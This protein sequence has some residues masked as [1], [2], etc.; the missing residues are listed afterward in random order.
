MDRIIFAGNSNLQ[1]LSW[2]F[3]RVLKYLKPALDIYKTHSELDLFEMIVH[4]SAYLVALKESAGVLEIINYP[5]FKACRI[6]L[7]GGNMKELLS[8]YPKIQ[9]FAKEN[10]CKRMEIVGRKGWEKV[11]KDHDAI[12]VVLTKEI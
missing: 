7:A 12:S 2:Q 9:L 10:N 11:H 4:K 1:E 6:W 5:K 8:F 3:I